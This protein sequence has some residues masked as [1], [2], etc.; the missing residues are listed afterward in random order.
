R[1]GLHRRSMMLSPPK[2]GTTRVSALIMPLIVFLTLILASAAL[3]IYG[4]M[5]GPARRPVVYVFK[6]LTTFLIIVLAASLPAEPASRYRLAIT[7]GLVLSLAGDVFLMLPGDRFVAGLAAFTLTHL[8]YLAA[9]TIEAP[10]A[11]VPAAFVLFAIAEAPILFVTWP[12]LQRRL[13]LPVLVYA[14]VLGAMAAQALTQALLN[15]IL[16][17]IAAAVGAALFVVSDSTLVYNRFVRPFRLSP[18]LVLS[19]YYAAQ[20]LIA[21]SVL[22]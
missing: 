9:F 2:A 3:T 18:L 4:E 17:A 15:P 20:I 8:A 21:L 16:P 12:R 1:P 22:P 6:P 11:A 10:F 14:A 7:L 5:T 19:T 13:R